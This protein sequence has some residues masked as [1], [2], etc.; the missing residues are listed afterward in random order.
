MNK[1]DKANST[2]FLIF[3]A[4]TSLVNTKLPIDDANPPIAKVPR[5]IGTVIGAVTGIDPATNPK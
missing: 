4:I 3:D 2:F 5:I 1:N